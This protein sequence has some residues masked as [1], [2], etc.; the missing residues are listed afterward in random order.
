MK[1]FD[2][3][4]DDDPRISIELRIKGIAVTVPRFDF[5]DEDTLDAIQAEIDAVDSELSPHRQQRMVM[6]ANFRPF[7][8][9]EEMAVLEGAKLGQLTFM[10]TTWTENSAMPLGEFVL[11]ADSSTES[12]GRRSG[13]TSSVKDSA[14]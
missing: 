7:C 9:D 10:M 3:P 5:I 12:T 8:T 13:R 11:S 2:I 6:L 4:D 1:S 14:A